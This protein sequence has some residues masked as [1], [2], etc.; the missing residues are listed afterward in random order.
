MKDLANENN[1]SKSFLLYRISPHFCLCSLLSYINVLLFIY[2]LLKL[3]HG[4]DDKVSL[5]HLESISCLR[6]F[7]CHFDE[8]TACC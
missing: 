5:I 4:Y 7:T 1:Q 6:T 3:T 2:P 8:I